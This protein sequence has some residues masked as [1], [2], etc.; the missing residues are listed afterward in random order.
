MV[1]WRVAA[2]QYPI[3]RLRDWDAYSDKLSHWV[4]ESDENGGALAVFPEY[5]AMEL[6]SLDPESMGNIAGSIE[7][8][9]DLLPQV[10][11]LHVELA[12]S[13]HIHILAASAPHKDPDGLV[14]IAARLF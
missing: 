12:A 2:A 3:D 13:H 4:A 7:A 6:A 1:S 8:V 10:D 14:S 11:A 5:G 9:S